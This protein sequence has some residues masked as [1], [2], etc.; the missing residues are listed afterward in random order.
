MELPLVE[1]MQCKV[2]GTRDRYHSDFENLNGRL[3]IY[4]AIINLQT[5]N[6]QTYD[7]KEEMLTFL[8]VLTPP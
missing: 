1:T 3:L 5:V 7:V 6:H 8:C 4:Y 2:E